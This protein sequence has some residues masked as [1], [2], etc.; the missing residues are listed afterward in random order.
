MH[1]ERDY[2][3]DLPD[4]EPH[5]LCEKELPVACKGAWFDEEQPSDRRPGNSTLEL[6]QP[7]LLELRVVSMARA[8]IKGK[9]RHNQQPS[10]EGLLH[11]CSVSL[12][13]SSRPPAHWE[14]TECPHQERCSGNQ[15]S[16]SSE[17]QTPP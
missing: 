13:M 3:N 11:W 17:T 2:S 15:D 14:T 10:S 12:L 8:D 16:K 7:W 5:P 4:S 9:R 1:M 6:A